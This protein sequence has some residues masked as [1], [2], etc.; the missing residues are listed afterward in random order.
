MVSKRSL[1]PR[2]EIVPPA[3]RVTRSEQAA[4]AARKERPSTSTAPAKRLN[5]GSRKT[6]PGAHAA[7]ETEESASAT[8]AETEPEG[9]SDAT[10]APQQ[11]QQPAV[12]HHHTT[13][14]EV[15]DSDDPSHQTA[16]PQRPRA[17]QAATAGSETEHV[18]DSD[19]AVGG[20][21]A[22]EVADLL[23]PRASKNKRKRTAT[24]SSKGGRPR[25]R[26]GTVV[27]ETDHELQEL[28]FPSRA[29]QPPKNSQVYGKRNHK[30]KGKEVANKKAVDSAASDVAASESPEIVEEDQL[31]TE[32]EVS[33]AERHEPVASTSKGKKRSPAKSSGRSPGKKRPA[34]ETSPARASASRRYTS[35]TPQPRRRRDAPSQNASVRISQAPNDDVEDRFERDYEGEERWDESRNMYPP[36]LFVHPR[37]GARGDGDESWRADRIWVHNSWVKPGK[38]DQLNGARVV[39]TLEEAH[40]AILPPWYTPGYAALLEKTTMLGVFPT[41]YGWV[42][43][44]AERSLEEGRP[45][46]LSRLRYIA[47]EPKEPDRRSK[48]YLRLTAEEQERFARL[49]A[50]WKS[51]DISRIEMLE[52]MQ[53]RFFDGTP[54]TTIDG[55]AASLAENEADIKALARRWQH[56]A[57][58][59]EETGSEDDALAVESE[60]E[61]FEGMRRGR[62]RSRPAPTRG[63]RSDAAKEAGDDFA[64]RL[65]EL[66]LSYRHSLDLI[67]SICLACDLDLDWAETVLHLLGDFERV[68]VGLTPD[69][70]EWQSAA[71]RTRKQILDH[72]EVVWHP[73]TDGQLRRTADGAL[74]D[75]AAGLGL[76][77]DVVRARKKLL[78]AVKAAGAKGWYPDEEG[79]RRVQEDVLEE[80][81][82]EEGT[83]DGFGSPGV[84][85]DLIAL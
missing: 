44:S 40:I 21:S 46:R 82:A 3:P 19:S 52:Q 10:P 59:A 72:D 17:G 54:R 74:A 75:I 62:S 77:V 61:A 27:A 22:D 85:E 43:E 23:T 48:R 26:Q 6:A 51:G 49:Y 2:M 39:D 79:L 32:H 29:R 28:A 45:V 65:T 11:Q 14:T 66:S 36:Q 56:G 18:A 78:E 57:H 73:K 68:V 16:Q 70:A 60:E 38:R 35:D 12:P 24:T 1:R 5:T 42:Q 71:A 8:E 55:Y 7:T 76:E 31:A 67:R 25:K 81:D 84:E 41:V 47:P 34:T 83:E 69:H 64:T 15:E 9:E 50:S 53:S 30:G 33:E 80:A 13:T 20:G 4:T 58:R 37:R 63:R